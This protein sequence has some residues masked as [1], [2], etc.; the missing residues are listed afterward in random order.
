[1]VASSDYQALL[2]FVSHCYLLEETP[3]EPSDTV[4]CETF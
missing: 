2:W 3:S 4:R 1:L